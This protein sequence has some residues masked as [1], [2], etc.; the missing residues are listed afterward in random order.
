MYLKSL[1]NHLK[2]NVDEYWSFDF[3]LKILN[4]W[5]YKFIE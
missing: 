2:D 3:D 1:M 4:M 5:Y